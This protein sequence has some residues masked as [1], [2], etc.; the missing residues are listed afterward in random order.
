MLGNLD[1]DESSDLSVGEQ[2]KI[3]LKS[4]S[5]RVIDLFREW[6]RD[7][8]GQ[9]GRP[10]F[11]KALKQLGLDVPKKEIDQ[12]FDQWDE[13][14]SGAISFDELKHLLRGGQRGGRNAG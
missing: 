9:I 5:A 2:L 13:D 1:L 3:A 11:H 8:D 12:L 10:D 14:R 7:G 4:S 6:D